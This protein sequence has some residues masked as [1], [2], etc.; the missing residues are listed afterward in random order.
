MDVLYAEQIDFVLNNLKDVKCILFD[1]DKTKQM[2]NNSFNYKNLISSNYFYF[3]Y[4]TNKKRSKINIH[5]VVILDGS[6]LK[7][8]VNELVDPCYSKYTILFKN[9]I[10]PF[11]I[12]I[13]AGAD[14]ENVVKGVFEINMSAI[15]LDDFFYKVDFSEM[16]TVFNALNISPKIKVFKSIKEEEIF[17]TNFIKSQIGSEMLVLDRSFDLITPLLCNWHYQS[18]ISQYFKYENFNVEIARKEYALKDDFFLKN[19]FNDIETV[20]ENLK[21]EVQDLERKRHNINNYQFDDI[22]GVTTLSKVVDI[23]MNVF[24]HVLD[25]TLRNQELGEVEIKILKGNSEDLVLFQKGSKEYVKLQIIESLSKRTRSSGL[26]NN[27]YENCMKKYVPSTY[28]FSFNDKSDLL[29]Y[30]SPV[31]KIFRHFVKK[32]LNHADFYK[33]NQIQG[34]S[35]T[36]NKIY[37][38]YM[39]NG[40]TYREY[41]DIMEQAQSLGVIVYVFTDKILTVENTL[42]SLLCENSNKK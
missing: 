27:I 5:A 42:K 39:R 41:K 8:L 26:Q 6:N 13:L 29:S 21:E 12:E 33:I 35:Q 7:L 31:K 24:K 25:E 20:G 22:E 36:E 28:S 32:K 15:K 16:E 23:N 38:I 9:A 30:E 37:L 14:R 17:K 11:A 10:D 1:C 2:I 18:A 34:N 40:A 3:D 4:L 19:K